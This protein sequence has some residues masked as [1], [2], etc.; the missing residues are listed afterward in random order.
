MLSLLLLSFLITGIAVPLWKGSNSEQ[1]QRTTRHAESLA[2]QL[3][4]GQRSS[5]RGPASVTFG[6]G[7]GP[8]PGPALNQ[9]TSDRGVI[10]QDLWGHAFRFQV[11]KNSQGE[12]VQIFV[13]SAGPNGRFDTEDVTHIA[14]DDLSA[15]V[16]MH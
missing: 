5:G 2:Y 3:M 12:K 8:G 15:S 10:G 7:T 9:L 11:L 6:P 14:G 13:V 16:S 1:V 4:E